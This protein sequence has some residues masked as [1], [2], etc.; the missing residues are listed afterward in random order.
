M[1]DSKLGQG[2]PCLDEAHLGLNETH[3]GHVLVG[4]ENPGW[5]LVKTQSHTWHTSDSPRLRNKQW[6]TLERK[7]FYPSPHL[8]QAPHPNPHRPNVKTSSP[9]PKSQHKVLARMQRT[10]LLHTAR[11]QTNINLSPLK[12]Q[13]K[14]NNWGKLSNYVSFHASAMTCVQSPLSDANKTSQNKPVMF[15]AHLLKQP[16][17]WKD[18]KISEPSQKLKNSFSLRSTETQSNKVLHTF[19]LMDHYIRGMKWNQSLNS[20]NI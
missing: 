9:T 8:S 19:T 7:Q 1:G 3:L 15:S 14:V 2:L 6:H 5:N 17:P 20:K 12:S 13:M 18:L 10:R 11:K 4:F 16:P